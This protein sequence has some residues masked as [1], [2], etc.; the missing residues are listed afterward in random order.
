M[1][2]SLLLLSLGLL[3]IACAPSN[4]PASLKWPVLG[5]QGQTW[6]IDIQKTG[7]WTLT[8]NQQVDGPQNDGT[9]VLGGYS[10]GN[11][12]RIGYFEYFS[13]DDHLT[14]WL[15]GAKDYF[16][17]EIGRSGLQGLTLKGQG[18]KGK[19]YNDPV[20]LNLPCTV[21]LKGGD[22]ATIQTSTITARRTSAVHGQPHN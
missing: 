10:S 21:A 7:H 4:T 14:L 2:S 8:L 12:R 3:F 18:V 13:D 5:K 11:E 6:E 16:G 17:C 22:A 20:A 9:K 15:D 1:K 19:L